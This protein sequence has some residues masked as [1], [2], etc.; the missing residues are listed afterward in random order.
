MTII[1]ILS[2]GR[3]AGWSLR[4]ATLAALEIVS[5][6]ESTETWSRN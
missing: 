2:V 4:R 3:I 1:V 6:S 5:S